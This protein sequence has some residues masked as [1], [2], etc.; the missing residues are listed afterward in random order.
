VD[1]TAERAQTSG[2]GAQLA[3]RRH[4]VLVVAIVVVFLAR[5]LIGA[6]GWLLMFSFVTW[7]ELAASSVTSA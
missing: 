2:P 4:T 3:A 5:P 7:T 1:V 6:I